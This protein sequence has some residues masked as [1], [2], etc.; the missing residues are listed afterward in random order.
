MLPCMGAPP[1]LGNSVVEPLSW[2]DS[3]SDHPESVHERDSS[4]RKCMQLQQPHLTPPAGK[5]EKRHS[6][7]PPE[8]QSQFHESKVNIILIPPELKPPSHQ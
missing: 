3:G 7:I 8:P 4:H 1:G 5:S 6:S 2:Y